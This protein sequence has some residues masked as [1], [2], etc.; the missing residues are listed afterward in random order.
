M[1]MLLRASG[2]VNN[3]FNTQKH[4]NHVKEIQNM[5]FTFICFVNR[6]VVRVGERGNRN[7]VGGF[8]LIENQSNNCLSSFNWNHKDPS[9]CSLEDIDPIFK[10]SKNFWNGSSDFSARV[11]ANIAEFWDFEVY[12]NTTF[13]VSWNIGDRK[14]DVF[15][16][17]FDNY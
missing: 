12:R 1:C 6:N 17:L 4:F 14:L 9:S 13:G 15:L 5:V 11:C 8:P 2:D 16:G 7:V 10:I 3:P